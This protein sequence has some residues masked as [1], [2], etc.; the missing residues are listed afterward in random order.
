MAKLITKEER[1]F[2]ERLWAERPTKAAVR[3]N[4]H[5]PN[6]TPVERRS[7]RRRLRLGDPCFWDDITKLAQA[8]A[9]RCVYCG[10]ETWLPVSAAEHAYHVM[11]IG[12]KAEVDARKRHG[13]RKATR[14]HL[15]RKCDGGSDD[16]CN[17][18]LA[19][20]F[21]NSHRGEHEPEIWAIAVLAMV[22]VRRHPCWL[23]ASRRATP[24]TVEVHEGNEGRR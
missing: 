13:W 2:V 18:A 11:P 3:E 16:L 21:C 7:R 19:C 9:D 17:L 5:I 22:R 1:D 14:E 4:R 15:I 10:C 8:A 20:A 12:T 24:P 6:P 23:D